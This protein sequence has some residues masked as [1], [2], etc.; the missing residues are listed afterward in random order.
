[1]KTVFSNSMLCHTWAN[2]LQNF[3]KGSS[4]Y[5]E[6]NTIYS[7]GSHY[8]IAQV[9]EAPNLTKV[10]FVNSNGYSNTTAKHT[11]HVW[12]AIPDNFP[13]FKIPFKI[14]SSY[15]SG[16]RTHSF[17]VEY[18][19]EII[20]AML[21]DV[22][23]T[24]TQQ[25]NARTYF[26]YFSAAC[27]K[28]DD[29]V[30][31]SELFNLPVPVRP[32]NFLEAQIKAEHLRETQSIREEKKQSKELQKNLEL[33]AKWLN[34]E[35]NGQLYNIPVHLR[36]SKDGKLIETTKGA[37]VDFSAAL[38]LLSKLRNSEDVNGYKIDGF[39]VLENNHKSVKIG[40]HQIDWQIINDLKIG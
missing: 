31:I 13:V 26:G 25:I 36:V 5:F 8:E 32:S 34:H 7:Y 15:Y 29:I 19:T 33:L 4:M 40:C 3:G 16:S 35:Y 21:L 18:L 11:N 23:N 10:F 22:E 14:R 30:N 27:Q 39:T 28:F 1:M 6:G 24:L 20:N 2:Q 37:K 9:I 38:R 12:R 17:K